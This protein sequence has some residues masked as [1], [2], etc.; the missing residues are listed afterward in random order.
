M[1]S[2]RW[3]PS[4]TDSRLAILLIMLALLLA[5]RTWLAEHPEHDP[6]APLDLRDPRGWATGAKLSALAD[7]P[8]QCRDVLERSEVAFNS[9]DPAGEGA[10]YRADRLVL[11]DSLLSPADTARMTCPLAAGMRMWI[12]KDL[13]PLARDMLGSEIAGIRQIG[14]YSCRRMY[15]A[16]SG[17]WSEH[18]T[19]NAIDI[20]GFTLADGRQLSLLAD[21]NGN[22]EEAAFL[23][24]ARDAAC[25]NFGTVLSPDYNAAHAD[26]FHLDQG[27]M[28]GFGA[29]R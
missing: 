28:P 18:A 23:R 14:T 12:D 5:G 13:Q 20:A 26:H 7:D 25:R 2:A 4:P 11:T 16:S 8:A 10:C 19:G 15:G 29:C 1:A 6:S 17:P 9:L 3:Q 21:W 22:E 24:A 27:R